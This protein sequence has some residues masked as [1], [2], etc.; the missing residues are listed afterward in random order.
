[1]H[2]DEGLI[3]GRYLRDESVKVR[4]GGQA[5]VYRCTDMATGQA[6][7]VKFVEGLFTDEIALRIFK[8]E[9]AA[10]RGLRHR[11]IVRYRDSGQD[12]DGRLFIVLDWLDGGFEELL[13]TRHPLPWDE[14]L[15]RYVGSSHLRV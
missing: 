14:A 11:G 5:S 3:A 13:A 4:Q 12:S 2:D 9:V 7:A 15:G 6:V 8:R 1:M 10:L